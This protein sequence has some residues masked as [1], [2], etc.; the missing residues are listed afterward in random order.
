MV[1]Q[2]EMSS[3]REGKGWKGWDL[4]FSILR[5]WSLGWRAIVSSGLSVKDRFFV[6]F[7]PPRPLLSPPP[8]PR[9]EV[10]DTVAVRRHHRTVAGGDGGEG[11]GGEGRTGAGT[12]SIY[13][14]R[15]LQEPDDSDPKQWNEQHLPLHASCRSTRRLD[16]SKN[17]NARSV[18]GRPSGNFKS[19]DPMG[20]SS[21]RGGHSS[22]R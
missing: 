8:H 15:M 11:R 7:S 6:L 14:M 19:A 13:W 3:G 2:M 18:T 12:G 5:V 20:N 17:H 21:V 16:I 22:C 4:P 10:T 1:R 9:V